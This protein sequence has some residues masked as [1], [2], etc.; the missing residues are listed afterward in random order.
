MLSTPPPQLRKENTRT[1][2]RWDLCVCYTKA[3]IGDFF[4]II[5]SFLC[6]Y[7]II[8]QRKRS[9]NNSGCIRAQGAEHLHSPFPLKVPPPTPTTDVMLCKSSFLQA[10]KLISINYNQSLVRLSRRFCRIMRP[11]CTKK[12]KKIV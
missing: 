2:S 4:I 12:L 11:L 3:H 5:F 1:S 6:Y 10:V 8:C 9:N 7:I